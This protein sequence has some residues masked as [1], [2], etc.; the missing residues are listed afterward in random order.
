[1]RGREILRVSPAGWV[2]IVLLF[3]IHQAE[4]AAVLLVIELLIPGGDGGTKSDG[5]LPEE[6]L[7]IGYDA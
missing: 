2:A 1:M 5:D 6:D 3:L 4:L 7:E